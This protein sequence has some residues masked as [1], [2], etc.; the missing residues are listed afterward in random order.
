MWDVARG[1]GEGRGH[2]I[3]GVIADGVD[4]KPPTP[5][6]GA[7]RH[8]VKLSFV[9]GQGSM[10]PARVRVR[11]GSGP[12]SDGPV[13]K[14]LQSDDPEQIVADPGKEA[15]FPGWIQ[16]LVADHGPNSNR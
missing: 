2:H 15:H 9:Q 1:G 5:R 12:G 4:A 11:E 10:A 13:G 14:G 3:D 6:G 16:E 8:L 7:G